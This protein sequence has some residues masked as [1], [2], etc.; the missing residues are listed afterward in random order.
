MLG[1]DRNGGC[2]ALW[3]KLI[4]TVVVN[5]AITNKGEGYVG[6]NDKAGYTT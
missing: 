4:D 1:V 3:N 6:T 5:A 2:M